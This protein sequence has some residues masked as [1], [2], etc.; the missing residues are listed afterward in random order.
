MFS[1]LNMF[2][3]SWYIFTI[4]GSR[5]CTRAGKFYSEARPNSVNW[6]VFPVL[7]RSGCITNARYCYLYSYYSDRGFWALPTRLSASCLLQLPDVSALRGALRLLQVLHIHKRH[8]ESQ[9]LSLAQTLAH[10]QEHLWSG[11][12]CLWHT[13]PCLSAYTTNSTHLHTSS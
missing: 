8:R 12:P 5:W 13:D 11:Y 2:V 3:G 1:M 7:D 4:Q 10:E 9:R 6:A